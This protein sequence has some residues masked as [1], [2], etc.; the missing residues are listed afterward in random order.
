MWHGH[1]SHCSGQALA[2]SGHGQ[3][4]LAHHIES[5]PSGRRGFWREMT[6]DS[7]PSTG[8]PSFRS[9]QSPL[10]SEIL[11]NSLLSSYGCL[12]LSKCNRYTELKVARRN[13]I[14]ERNGDFR[15]D[16]VASCLAAAL[17]SSRKG[18]RQVLPCESQ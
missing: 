8:L 16:L 18:D 11:L 5:L 14:V 3:E 6:A 4:A 15:S 9:V 2:V 13:T 17:F 10:N 1:P 12:V 7:Q